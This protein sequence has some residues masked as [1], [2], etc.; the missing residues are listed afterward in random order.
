MTE[1]FDFSGRTVFVAG[2][3][4]G[5]NLGVAQAFAREGAAVAVL[6][7]SP[8]K[9]EAAV[10]TLAEYR[11]PAVGFAADVREYDAVAEAMSAASDQLGEFDVLV[12][13]AAGNFPATARDMSARAFAAVVDI[14]LKGTFHV[15]RAAYEHLRKP[16]ATVINISAP[17]SSI[18]MELQAHACAAKAGVDMV[19]R[20]CALEWG[21]VGIRVNA[22]APGP[23]SGTEGM[24][25]LAPTPDLESLVTDSVPL[26]RYGVA[27]EIADCCLWLASPMASY[28]TG[29]VIPVDGG[30]SLGGASQ[31]FTGMRKLFSGNP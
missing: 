14:D 7:R 30:W 2:G 23:I 11:V 8:V 28:V 6:S 25:R 4:S 21:P 3:T 12:S 9:V 13:G 5:I 1:Q 31:L 15:L 18:A 27:Q 24:A 26:G 20:V 16:G 29:A 22:I 17:Q 10:A 19:T